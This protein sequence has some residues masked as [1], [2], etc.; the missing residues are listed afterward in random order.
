MSDRAARRGDLGRL[1]RLP[2]PQGTWV[3]AHIEDNRGDL[4]APPLSDHNQINWQNLTDLSPFITH[5]TSRILRVGTPYYPGVSPVQTAPQPFIT[6]SW[7]CRQAQIQIQNVHSNIPH[8]EERFICEDTRHVTRFI[9]NPRAS[10]LNIPR[11]DI[12]TFSFYDHLIDSF[13]RAFK[14]NDHV[15]A[16]SDRCIAV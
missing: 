1:A 14:S 5:P 6:P 3:R 11:R 13:T 2:T 10:C 12:G 16:T 7:A 15:S 4:L 8:S 9:S